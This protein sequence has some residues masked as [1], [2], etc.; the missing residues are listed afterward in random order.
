MSDAT[1]TPAYKPRS[2]PH[3]CFR[4]VKA[5]GK[6]RSRAAVSAEASDATHDAKGFAGGVVPRRAVEPGVAAQGAGEH[7]ERVLAEE[8]APVATHRRHAED[9]RRGRRVGARAQFGLD[10]VTLRVAR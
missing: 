5:A 8:V 10:V 4:I 7:L 9:A 1:P 2:N 6:P 3:A